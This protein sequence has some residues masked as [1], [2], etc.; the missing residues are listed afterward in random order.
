MRCIFFPCI[1]YI[2]DVNQRNS[3][4]I[5]N[6]HIYKINIRSRIESVNLQVICNVFSIK[7][8]HIIYMYK[9]NVEHHHL[10]ENQRQ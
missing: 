9:L 5:V 7:A 10:D 6:V 3:L 4:D 1:S 8:M 2:G